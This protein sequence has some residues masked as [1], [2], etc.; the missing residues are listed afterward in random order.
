MWKGRTTESGNFERHT[1]KDG[2]A[3]NMKGEELLVI[4]GR[5]GLTFL[6]IVN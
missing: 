5:I 4:C 1:E 3:N 2:R 6:W